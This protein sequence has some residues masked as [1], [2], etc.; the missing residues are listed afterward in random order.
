MQNSLF[1]TG[2]KKSFPEVVEQPVSWGPLRDLH[3]AKKYRAL[4]DPNTGKLFSIVTKDYRLI[5][6]EEAIDEVESAIDH[7]P[8]L[9][10]AGTITTEFFNDGG[11]MRRT[12]RFPDI[13]IEIGKGD[14]VNLELHLFNSYDVSWPF[15]VLLGAFRLICSNG[16]VIGKRFL[17]VRKRHVFNLEKLDLEAEISTALNRFTLQT[18]EW[19]RWSSFQLTP[20]AHNKVMEHMKFGKTA[21]ETIEGKVEREAAGHDGEGFP[22]ITLWVFYN[23]LT[24]Y[25][26]FKTVSLNHRVEMERRLRDAMVHLKGK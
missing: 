24:W 23:I 9:G 17:Y 21:K 13:A 22:I 7:T 26:T 8:A 3:Q 5:R 11:R 14:P 10:N 1:S 25:I 16:L 12:Y 2:A 6:H 19:E 15:I 18:K 20:A 4:V